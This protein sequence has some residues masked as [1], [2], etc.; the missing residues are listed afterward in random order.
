MKAFRSFASLIPLD[1]FKSQIFSLNRVSFFTLDSQKTSLSQI[2]ESYKESPKVYNESLDC[3]VRLFCFLKEINYYGKVVQDMENEI[4]SKLNKIKKNEVIELLD[5]CS[6]KHKEQI[7]KY[8]FSNQKKFLNTQL[9]TAAVKV[10]NEILLLD[11]V[12]TKKFNVLNLDIGKKIL[13]FTKRPILL[14]ELTNQLQ[15]LVNEENLITYLEIVEDIEKKDP[16]LV[17]NLML[18]LDELL[19][20]SNIKLNFT[21]ITM[22]LRILNTKGLHLNV[23]S[24]FISYFISCIKQDVNTI[25]PSKAFLYLNQFGKMRFNESSIISKLI[26][27]FKIDCSINGYNIKLLA[28]FEGISS[29]TNY[30]QELKEMFHKFLIE[31]EKD[32]NTSEALRALKIFINEGFYYDKFVDMMLSKLTRDKCHSLSLL[33]KVF[34]VHNIMLM[35]IDLPEKKDKLQSVI[36]GMD[37]PANSFVLSNTQVYVAQVLKSC[38]VEFLENQEINNVYEIDILI[39]ESKIVIEVIGTLYHFFLFSKELTPRATV[40]IRHLVKLGYKIILTVNKESTE[41]HLKKSLLFLKNFKNYN[42]L[43]LLEDQIKVIDEY[44]PI[45]N[46]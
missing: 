30:D 3:I 16:F 29:I 35:T 10:R 13:S 44:K 23:S 15:N 20:K 38:N 42:A 25:D 11:L 28:G 14:L 4:L 36:S 40:K 2:L 26:D 1:H 17:K 32:I 19:V 39:P 31:N 8:V 21:T 45:I 5:Y 12:N 6:P 27:L 18:Y 9:T 7:V 33:S 22:I 46:Q 37:K 43:L 41:S 34:L 24:N